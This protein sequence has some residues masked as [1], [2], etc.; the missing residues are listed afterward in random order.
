[1]KSRGVHII[2]KFIRK[3]S[4]ISCFETKDLIAKIPQA[5][6]LL[7]VMCFEADYFLVR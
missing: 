6:V 7:R 5:K 1:M 4:D 3:S 2:A